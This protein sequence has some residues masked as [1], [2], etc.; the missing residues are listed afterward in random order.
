MK[1]LIVGP[2]LDVPGGVANY[3]KLMLDTLTVPSAYHTIGRRLGEAGG[4]ASFLRMVKDACAFLR[5]LRRLKPDI[6]HLNP[7]LNF[8]ALLRD[9]VLLQL[10]RFHIA[11]KLVFV[12]GWNDR[13]AKK[14]THPILRRFVVW[15]LA[16]AHGFIVL[17]A[18][19]RDALEQLGV[20]SA[21]YVETVA[22]PDEAGRTSLKIDDDVIRILFLSRIEEMKGA[23]AVI[24]T[25]RMLLKSGRKVELVI[26]GDGPDLDRARR[27]VADEKIANVTFAGYV[28]DDAK[29]RL[30]EWASLFLFPT[31]YGEGLPTCVLEAMSYGL[32]VITT[33]V[34]G[35]RDFFEDGRMGLLAHSTEPEVLAALVDRLIADPAMRRSMS[36]MN[37][38]YAKER[39]N[40]SQVAQ[41][42][43]DVY[44]TLFDSGATASSD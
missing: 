38:R 21:V 17:C 30:L 8:N 29:H 18:A 32:P 1:I 20:R 31:R 7:S 24:H 16:P 14:L 33:P 44:T 27:T 4:V 36:A 35:I 11:R 26:A 15:G 41:R 2:S 34:G 22:V 25:H 12:H 37:E 10:S 9:I 40:A 5:H 3:C 39:F 43:S 13:V 19:H 28:V 6:V 23:L 42:L